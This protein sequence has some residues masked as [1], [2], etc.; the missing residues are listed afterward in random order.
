MR[1]RHGADERRQDMGRWKRTLKINDIWAAS[2]RGEIT[3][4]GLGAQIA[5]RLRRVWV[6]DELDLDIRDEVACRFESIE[7]GTEEF[8][9]I[10][11]D[12]YDWADENDVWVAAL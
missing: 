4:E 8:D 1:I 9:E 11:S 5:K 7:G 6:V 12:L 2:A 10:M 3:V